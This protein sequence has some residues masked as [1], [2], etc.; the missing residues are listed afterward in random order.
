[1][2]PGERDGVRQALHN[3][4]VVARLRGDYDRSVELFLQ[5]R[6]ICDEI[7]PTG[8]GAMWNAFELGVTEIDRENLDRADEYFRR[9]ENL[10]SAAT[11]GSPHA[12]L[13]ALM[14]S[15]IAYQRK[16]LASTE[17]LLRQA[18]DYY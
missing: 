3:L 1:M 9:S 5:E 15:K 12:A 6:E 17:M 8:R 4:G 18:R 10:G 16:D 14:R 11:A 7:A 2:G 13:L